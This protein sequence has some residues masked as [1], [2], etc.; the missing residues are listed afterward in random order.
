MIELKSKQWSMVGGKPVVQF[1]GVP[2]LNPKT[3]TMRQVIVDGVKYLVLS[4]TSGATADPTG[5]PF[6][7][8]LRRQ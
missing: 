3:L 7:M 6:V 2:K 4:V 1:D 5:Q 8:V